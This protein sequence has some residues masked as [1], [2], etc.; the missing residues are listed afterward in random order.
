MLTVKHENYLLCK[1]KPFA[2]RIGNTPVVSI[3]NEHV[4][5]FA[6]LEYTNFV[7]SIKDRA[8][9]GIIRAGIENGQINEETTLIEASSGNFALSTAG[10]CYALGL[11]FVAVID[12][13]INRVYEQLLRF[14]SSQ[15]IVV[16]EKDVNDGYLLTKIE[17]VKHFCESHENV[18]W[19]NQYENVENYKAHF[20]GTGVE[21]CA[22]MEQLDYAFIATASGGTIAGVSNRL[23]QH[24]PSVRVVAVDAVGSV[25]FGGTPRQRFIPGMGSGMVPPQVEH[26]NIDEV[27]YVDENEAIQGCHQLVREHG[28]FLG[29]SSGAVYSAI[30][31]YFKNMKLDCRPNVLF[32]CP[33]RGL[34]Y[35]DNVFNHEWVS[36]MATRV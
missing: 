11:K 4:N 21:I 29:G 30:L 28:L 8:A 14:F 10:L 31:K 17:A 1:L 12:P 5:L 13:G 25:I 26:A 35:A 32:I 18:F 33:D 20:N 9:L 6:K 22:D 2:Q 27:V 16:E 3:E 36:S 23:K 7:G 15:V 19:T 34:G 24:F